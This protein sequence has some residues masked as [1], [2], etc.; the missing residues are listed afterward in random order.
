VRKSLSK[1]SLKH[2]LRAGCPNICIAS[3]SVRAY[4]DVSI[5]DLP[6]DAT[7]TTLAI[8]ALGAL[9]LG[10][11]KTGFPGLAIVNVMIVAEL[12]GARESVG[13]ILPMLV[14]CDLIVLPMFWKHATWKMV[15]PLVPVT[16]V[17]IIVASFLLDRFDDLTARRVI[18][19]IILLMFLLQLVREFKKA[20]L[21]KLPDSRV[22]RWVS[23]VLIGVSTMLANAAGP[24]YSIY[25]L[26]HKMP[27]ME[28]LGV[29]ARL[30]L[31]VNLFKVPLLGQLDLINAQSLQLNLMLLPA[32]L[33]GIFLGRKLIGLVPQRIFEILLYGF[34]LIAGVRMLFF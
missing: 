29:G 2:A 4:G 25:A 26:V 17:A 28:F 12:F 5:L 16:F 27:K 22:F 30:F 8:A 1:S 10:V 7:S 24:V 9:C 21:T 18:G 33:V 13:I 23:C 31:I 20:F 3:G 19:T 11:S 32:L 34:S 15:W 14:V 6:F